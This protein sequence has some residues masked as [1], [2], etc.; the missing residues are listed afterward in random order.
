MISKM[1]IT[2]SKVGGVEYHTETEDNVEQEIRTLMGEIIR[3]T[4]ISVLCSKEGIDAKLYS[5]WSKD[6]LNITRR[7][8]AKYSSGAS[9]EGEIQR[10]QNENLILTKLVAELNAEVQ[11]LKERLAVK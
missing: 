6:F 4:N 5:Q 11:L 10:L 8:L 2:K 9:I 3:E 1:Q 7:K